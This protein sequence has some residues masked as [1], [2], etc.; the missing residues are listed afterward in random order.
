MDVLVDY[1]E[2]LHLSFQ[3]PI[4]NSIKERKNKLSIVSWQKYENKLREAV[5]ES[6]Q[7]FTP[8]AANN[9]M[10]ESGLNGVYFCLGD[11]GG[12]LQIAGSIYYNEK[13]W[14]AN[15]DF[16]AECDGACSILEEISELLRSEDLE[17]E[18]IE[19]IEYFF[20][21]FVLYRLMHNIDV[22]DNLANAGISLGYSDGD[23]LII[24]HFQNCNFVG[25]LKVIN[26]HEKPSGEL[27]EP[28]LI[29]RIAKR[30]ALWD[31]LHRNYY[32]YLKEVGQED[33]FI[34][35]GEAEAERICEQYKNTIF[36]NRCIKC[37]F[38]KMTPKASLCLNC[39]DFNSPHDK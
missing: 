22:H 33:N 29:N 13:D 39:S 4:A 26:E 34:R 8:V 16:Y 7:K 1:E 2:Y 23:E 12:V 28:V 17:R 36:V 19:T 6:L 35:F 3:K 15:A 24:G 27:F 10:P 30:G 20:I 5:I 37:D 31:Y 25:E 21:S 38:I 32:R 11:N 14:A 9:V 18:Y